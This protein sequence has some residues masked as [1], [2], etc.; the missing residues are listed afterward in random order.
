MPAWSRTTG[1]RSGPRGLWVL[2]AGERLFADRRRPAR[3]GRPRCKGVPATG[4][5]ARAATAH[6]R[7]TERPEGICSCGVDRDGRVEGRACRSPPPSSTGW[8]PAPARSGSPRRRTACCG[9]S[10]RGATRS[11]DV[12][13]GARGVAVA[14]G[15]VW[16]ANAARGTVTRIDPRSERRRRVIR[17]G[18]APRALASD[19][20]R[21]WVTRRGRWRRAR[22]RRGTRGERRGHRARLRRGAS[23]AAASP[24]RLI[25][26]DLPLHQPGSRTSRRRDRVRAAQARLPRGPL[27]HRLP[28][29]RRLDRA[30]GRLRAA[31]V[32]R[33]RRALRTRA[34]RHRD[35][36]PLQL[37]LRVRAARDH[38]PRR[39]AGDD[40][41][42]E[43]GGSG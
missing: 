28:V 30:A 4:V 7:C 38:Q 13:A 8:R 26:S 41:A 39:P 2:G 11:I 18:N 27:R 31:Q 10:T 22:A 35:R 12:G 40:L 1:S 15:A 29:V 34:A 42:D 21:L 33:E 24:Q 3:P 5:V 23:R 9:G 25:V 6:G 43:H 16:V 14:G 17:L 36:R 20:E 32:P 37:G 19:G